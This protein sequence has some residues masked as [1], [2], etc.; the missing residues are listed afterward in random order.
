M[1][2]VVIRCDGTTEGGLGHLVRALSVAEAACRAGW[3]VT[4]AGE[5]TSPLGRGLLSRSG[6]PVIPSTLDLGLLALGE[7]ADVIHVD[8]YE[9]SVDARAQVHAAGAL[10]SSME[11]G[12]FGRR[13]ADVVVDSSV[14]SERPGSISMGRPHDGSSLVLRGVAYAPMRSEVLQARAERSLMPDPT[15]PLHVLVVLGGTDATGA[16]AT[17]A[18]V[19][20]GAAGVAD[21]TVVAPRERWPSIS[22]VAGDVDLVEPGPDFLRRATRSDLVV[23]AAGTTTWELACIGVPSLIMAVVEN[24]IAGYHAVIDQG[25]GRGL[26]TL[27]EVRANP[28]GA[29]RR[30]EDAVADLRAG[31][32]WTEAGLRAV[33]GRGAERI[34]AAW[35]ELLIRS[36][37]VGSGAGTPGG[38]S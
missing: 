15:G 9:V 35:Q 31:R 26:G 19:C 11:D 8:K 33:D 32:S 2:R 7:R 36:G 5:V 3:D 37:P 4:V 34:V 1:S 6:L 23:S 22:A 24:Q 28:I 13:P 10:L 38:V 30:V 29:R 14:G 18:A 20:S 27:E 16:S 12:L 21:V 25:I 17:V